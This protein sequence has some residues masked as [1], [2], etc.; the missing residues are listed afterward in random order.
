MHNL[1]LILYG[2]SFFAT[3]ICT[4]IVCNHKA[5]QM[6]KLSMLVCISVMAVVVGFLLKIQASEVGGLITAQ[7]LIYCSVQFTAFFMLLFIMEYCRFKMNDVLKGIFVAVNCLIAVSGLTMD[8]HPFFY[9]RY[10]VEEVNGLVSLDKEYGPM[11][12]VATATI[13]LYMGLMVFYVGK[14]CAQNIKKRRAGVVKVLICVLIPGIAFLMPKFISTPYE[15]HPIAFSI[16]TVLL[17][18]LVYKDSIYDF[19]NLASSYIY[20][21]IDEAVI[22]C[23]NDY[24]FKG[25][26]DKAIELF[27]FLKDIPID[28]DIRELS[29]LLMDIY[30]EGLLE[31]EIDDTIY[32]VSVRHITENEKVLGKVI[33]LTDV[34]MERI[35]TRLLNEQKKSLESEV[36]TLSDISYKDEMTGLLNRRCYEETLEV[37][38]ESGNCEDISVM[39]LDVNGLK[40]ANDTM[41]HAV[42]D[43]L[44]KGAADLISN[45]FPFA[46]NFRVGGDEFVVIFTEKL[47]NSELY[48]NML[49]EQMKEFT[50][51]M[52]KELSVSYGFVKGSDYPDETIEGLLSLADKAMYE[53]KRQY[54][55]E[56]GIDRRGR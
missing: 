37:I 13:I 6:Q 36:E 38:K 26:N 5:C 41:G 11:H 19:T 16:F 21:S 30:N 15:F 49:K 35:Y 45:V 46:K 34:T 10:W 44:I 1:F 51:K 42:G 24:G 53:C 28:T 3:M 43:E 56:K 22:V 33:W 40:A 8:Y 14:Y 17:V 55:Q 47:I 4:I 31:Y 23:N 54:Y 32:D 18:V 2:I 7:K 20:K 27:P 39:A 52:V 29:E 48:I 12:T 25:C 9:K 50:G